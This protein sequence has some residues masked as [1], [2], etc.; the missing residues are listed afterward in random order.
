MSQFPPFPARAVR[1]TTAPVIATR[2][3]FRWQS[4][5]A[6]L[7]ALTGQVGTLTRAATGTAVDANGA[8]YTAVYGAPRWEMRDY[9]ASGTRRELGLRLAA[10]DLE[11][12]YNG[13]PETGT[14]AFAFSENGTGTTLN[15]GLVYLG[16]DAQTGARLWVTSDGTRY[17]ATI[18]NGTTSVSVTLASL[19]LT[20]GDAARGVVQLNDDGTNWSIKL[21]VRKL[22]GGTEEATAFSST[23]ARAAT[24]GAT[25]K[26]RANRVGSAGTQG[27][28]WLREIAWDAGLLTIDEAFARM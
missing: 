28:T 16:N 20:T 2:S 25:T 5:R 27:S 19:S 18:H 24:W 21:I 23:I 15:A 4:R 22:V 12:T 14:L 11:W 3:R 10:D 6:S 26:I 1:R 7:I 13:V 9:L 17:R 8:S